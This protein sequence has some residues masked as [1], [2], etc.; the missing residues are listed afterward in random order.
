MLKIAA[1]VIL[2]CVSTAM[3][4]SYDPISENKGCIDVFYN[5]SQDLF[6]SSFDDSLKAQAHVKGI[7]VNSYNANNNAELQFKQFLDAGADKCTKLVNLSDNFYSQPM[8]NTAIENNDTLIFFNNRP[9]AQA[10][11]GNDRAWYVGSNPVEIGSSQGKMILDYL[12]NHKDYDRNNNGRVD[13][14]LFEG[15]FTDHATEFITK[16]M[17]DELRHNGVLYERVATINAGWSFEKAFEFMQEFISSHSLKDIDLIVSN[18]DAMALGA[19]QSL[20]MHGYNLEHSSK[21]KIP[22]FG[23]DAIPEALFAIHRGFLAGTVSHDYRT[24]AKICID[25]S[26]EKDIDILELSK[27]YQFPI[28][29]NY[30]MVPSNFTLSSK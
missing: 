16:K 13:I 24:I 2:G 21:N 20:Q 29:D 1:L 28:R 22:V 9:D 25:I 23:I 18:N 30:V 4:N 15:S 8:A 17:I 7:K 27:K 26:Q 14:L 11:I 3:A 12:K 6:M 19:I 10:M 5:N